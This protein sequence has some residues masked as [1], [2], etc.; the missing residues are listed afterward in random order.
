VL[1][2]LFKR[3]VTLFF[4]GTKE[5]PSFVFVSSFRVVT[6]ARARSDTGVDM[7]AG[8]SSLP[9]S[10]CASSIAGMTS[11]SLNPFLREGSG[12]VDV[13]TVRGFWCADVRVQRFPE[14]TKRRVQKREGMEF[15]LIEVVFC[16]N[17]ISFCVSDTAGSVGGL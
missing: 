13:C 4:V 16:V 17:R 9:E 12:E 14:S 2:V 6:H 3:G 8:D 5:S 1:G 10:P 15:P 7:L 11:D